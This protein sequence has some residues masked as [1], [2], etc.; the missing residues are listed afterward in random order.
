MRRIIDYRIV[1]SK[2]ATHNERRA[3]AFIR[4]NI[5]LVTGCLVPVVDDGQG[6][7]GKEIIVG[8]T[9]REKEG[10]IK[11]RDRNGL[12][13]YVIKNDGERLFICGLGMPDTPPE[14]Y[15][16]PYRYI[17]E[18]D[19]GTL[20][21]AYRFVEDFLGYS[22]IYDGYAELKENRDAVIPQSCNIE[23]TNEGLKSKNI[24]LFNGE[25][26]Y[27]LPVTEHLHQNLMSFVIKTN[28]GK[29]IVIDG[30]QAKETENLLGVLAQLTPDGQIPVVSAWLLTHLH[31][32]HYGVITNIIN[33]YGEYSERIKIES[34][35]CNLL[36]DEFYSTL[37]AEAGESCRWYKPVRDALLSCE[38]KIGCKLYAVE[39]GDKIEVDDVSFMV[40]HVPEMQYAKKMSINDS[41]VVYKM[42]AGC[43]QT[44]L[45]LG[46]AESV[47][48]NDL[49]ENHQ[50]E[51]KSDVVQ[52]GHHGGGSVSPECYRAIDAKYYLW[53]AGNKFWYGEKGEGLG[54]HN[55]G[56]IRTRNLLR[57]MGVPEKAIIR[58]TNGIVG[59]KFPIN[60]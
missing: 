31:D 10:F 35:Y 14:V 27:M 57:S 44:V 52:V 8:C 53:Q 41:S 12:Y 28:S 45:F 15:S 39:C 46:D 26:I 9:N 7:V 2:N 5:R 49:L 25:C 59:M 48:S 13:Q 29:L 3:A 16:N 51:L 43:G 19:I 18:G 30:G 33:R 40:I 58:D 54:T 42:T 20:M 60:R 17:D 32:D 47:C 1:I 22:F 56:L 34:F 50:N 4:N 24:P 11:N 55:I 37:S 21:G 38:E 6:A 36:C 23:Y